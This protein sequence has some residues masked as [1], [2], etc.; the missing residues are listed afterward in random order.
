MSLLIALYLTLVIA[1]PLALSVVVSYR[2][3]PRSPLCPLCGKETMRIRSRWL[4]TLSRIV[5]RQELQKR[6]CTNCLWEGTIRI[7][8]PLPVAPPTRPTPASTNGPRAG[9]VPGPSGEAISIR[10]LEIDGR[11][12]R[13]LLQC[14]YDS[15]QWF[16]RLLFIAPSGRLWIDTVEP[17]RGTSSREV[18]SKALAL[19]DRILACRLREL[20]SDR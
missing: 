13:V 4:D 3:L 15:D 12:W 18:M 20:I 10:D 8:R 16:G 9:S 6:W 17:I 1:L 14:W 2:T 7:P 19:P 11:S 5:R